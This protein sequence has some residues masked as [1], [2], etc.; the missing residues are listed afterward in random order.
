MS[1]GRQALGLVTLTLMIPAAILLGFLFIVGYLPPDWSLRTTFFACSFGAGISALLLKSILDVMGRPEG[2]LRL[3]ILGGLA[4]AILG[5]PGLLNS[6]PHI[7]C[8]TL[9]L[10]L[11]RLLLGGTVG[12]AGLV[13]THLVSLL[14]SDRPPRAR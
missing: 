8:R 5:L 3:W 4:L 14:L 10:G 13:A 1:A 12:Y 7:V 2:G 11:N 9:G 6:P